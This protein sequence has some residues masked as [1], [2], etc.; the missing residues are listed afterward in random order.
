VY[1]NICECSKN[2]WWFVERNMWIVKHKWDSS[3]KYSYIS[4]HKNKYTYARLVVA[5]ILSEVLY[6]RRK[7]TLYP[8]YHIM[9]SQI[10]VLIVIIIWECEWLVQ[11]EDNK[12]ERMYRRYSTRRRK[13]KNTRFTIYLDLYVI[14]SIHILP[15]LL[16]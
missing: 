2:I 10:T 3:P 13:E 11:W 8:Y 6:I 16:V 12:N 1:W 7:Q 4:T 15:C 9:H 5:N 14:I